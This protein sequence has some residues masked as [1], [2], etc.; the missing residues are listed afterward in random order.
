MKKD[1]AFRAAFFS[2]SLDLNYSEKV[3]GMVTVVLPDF[4]LLN[5][6]RLTAVL[7]SPSNSP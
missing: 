3:N 7:I 4:T 5:F 1:R 2:V 6:Q